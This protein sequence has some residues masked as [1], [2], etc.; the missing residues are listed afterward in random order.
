M[1]GICSRCG[2]DLP[3]G[4]RFCPRCGASAEA[5]VSAERKVV[6]VVFADL[7]GSTSLASELDPER[8]RELQAAFYRAASE[9]IA[10]LRG[11]VEKFIGDAVMA[12]FGLPGA[13]EDDALRGVRAAIEIRDRAATLGGE[14]GLPRGIDVRIGVDSGPV[15][16][17]AGPADQLLVSGAPVNRAARL[18]QAALAGEILAGE[19]TRQLTM[20][21][22]RFGS[23]RPIEAKGFA[24]PV[25]AS[26][27]EALT[28]RSSRRVIP[29]VGRR[30][31]LTMLR[32]TLARVRE[33]SRLHLVTV[34]GEPGIGKSRI[35][36]AFLDLAG[37]GVRVRRGRASRFE[38][39]APFAPLAE[40]VRREIGAERT[41]A[42]D[43]TRELL[44]KRVAELCAPE[45]VTT[46]V[47]RLAGVLGLDAK[48]PSDRRYRTALVR[49]AFRSFLE[50]LASEGPVIVAFDDLELARPELLE[51]IEGIATR[52]RR[53]AVLIVCVGRD[54]MLAMRPGWGGGLTDAIALRIEPLP[55]ADA[56]EL[57][58]ASASSLDVETAER[59][60]QHSGG[61]PFFIVETTGMLLHERSESAAS[62]PLPPTVQAVVATRI[63]HLEPAARDLVRKA[64]VFAR[65]TFHTTELAIV[66]DPS[67]EAL[68]NLEDEELLVRDMERPAVWRFNHQVVRDVA[69][70]S[71]PKRERLRLHLALADR[72]QVEGRFPAALAFHL[73]RAAW[74]SLD[75]DPADRSVAERAA[76]A[77][78]A[79][80]DV[81]RRR[82]ESETAIDLYDRGL[83]LGPSE[84]KWARREARVLCGIGESSYWLGD[85]G[86][87]RDALTRALRLMPDDDWTRSVAHRFLGDIALNIDNDLA[88]AA[89]HFDEALPASR[90][91]PSTDAE[92]AVARTLL[93]AGWVSYMSNDFDGA[94]KTFEEALATARANPE[95]DPWAEA[96]ALTFVSNVMSLLEPLSEY[97]PLL[98]QAL[99][100]GRKIN[101][102]FS[103]AVAEQHF[104]NALGASGRLEEAIPHAAAA[105]AVFA[106]LGARWETAS[107]LGDLGELERLA[108]RLREAEEHQREAVSVCRELGDRQLIGWISA[109]LALSL[110]EQGR[111]RE[112]AAALE[113]AAPVVDADADSAT[114]RARARLAMDEGD[115]ASALDAVERLL[116]FTRDGNRPNAVARSVWF[117]ARLL[118]PEAVGGEDEVRRARDRLEAVGWKTWLEEDVRP[119]S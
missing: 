105:A 92:F 112:A 111:G 100:I 27:V 99:A 29:L 6:T 13:H 51:L 32:E 25:V 78:L 74:A 45:E 4:A 23:E 71:L 72:L 90:R 31:E 21:S 60:A 118:G 47:D 103:T 85:F 89:A 108:G 15:V 101:D 30:R 104:A 115:R 97:R 107:A 65:S 39:D 53:S 82:M 57:A 19:T 8:F 61:N 54:E 81:A 17:G 87:A 59:V 52:S 41:L 35:V 62:P 88:V 86:R 75:L 84:E 109:E 114:L 44:A 91:L 80:G 10:A 102:P 28:P 116:K 11:R 12:V 110:R 33:T 3:L 36:D 98:E 106:E 49:S 14:L 64:S 119:R 43:E 2:A 83:T 20:D 18:Q 93:M 76:D 63:D 22:I 94:R 37:D 67:D 38:E 1:E 16:V 70:E 55:P 58:R 95:G 9:S 50:G 113:E 73:E 79:A 46:T 7:A 69:Y 34:L 117:G 5:P 24:D 77:L 56:V 96:R 68:R 48:E 66:A 42:P 26:P 40:I